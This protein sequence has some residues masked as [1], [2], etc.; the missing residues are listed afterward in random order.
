MPCAEL[1]PFS[2]LVA[3]CFPLCRGLL[4]FEDYELTIMEATITKELLV[5]SY[6][7]HKSKHVFCRRDLTGLSCV[8]SFSFVQLPRPV[9]SA[10]L[11]VFEVPCP[12]RI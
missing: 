1:K 4:V 7:R 8:F 6:V 3:F 11:L 12:V 9:S 2:T 5:T 10:I